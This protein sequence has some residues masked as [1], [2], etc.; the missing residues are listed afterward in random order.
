MLSFPPLS[1]QSYPEEATI[2]LPFPSPLPTEST[3]ISQLQLKDC[4][5]PCFD[6]FSIDSCEGVEREKRI[7]DFCESLRQNGFVILE[8]KTLAPL[9]DGAYRQTKEYFKSDKVKKEDLQKG[10]E[11]EKYF[12]EIYLFNSESKEHPDLPEFNCTLQHYSNTI[13]RYTECTLKLVLEHLN[14]QKNEITV[15]QTATKPGIQL[16][17]YTPTGK[18]NVDWLDKHKDITLFAVLPHNPVSGLQF[19]KNENQWID[20]D[21]PE[22]YLILIAGDQLEQKTAGYFRAPEHSVRASK[23]CDR[24]TAGFSI[25]WAN[26]FSLKPL[27]SCIEKMCCNMSEEEKVAFLEDYPDL[28]VRERRSQMLIEIGAK[29]MGADFIK[30]LKKSNLIGMRKSQESTSNTPERGMGL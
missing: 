23:W 11:R 30:Q 6:V 29:G 28:T 5:L 25:G 26:D 15:C 18:E 8:E 9:I 14:V 16:M 13:S 1:L 3:C 20:A 21:I 12:R 22:G 27:E 17:K 2:S 10:Y 19:I 4:T 7:A 24:Y